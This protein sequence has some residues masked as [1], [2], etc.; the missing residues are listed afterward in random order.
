M[1]QAKINEVL[2]KIDISEFQNTDVQ[3]L[4]WGCGQGLATVCLFD[5]F[6]QKQV[7]LES[8]QQVVLI[9]PSGKAL[10]RAGTHVGAYINES[11]TVSINK[12]LDEIT[13]EEIESQCPVT[14]HLFSN[15]LDIPTID[16]QQLANKIKKSVWQAFLYLYGTTKRWKQQD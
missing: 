6:K 12:Y 7:P 8:V 14:I 16:L 1:H 3:I 15:I 11:R 13:S 2:P 9:E 5:Y 4:D 10:E